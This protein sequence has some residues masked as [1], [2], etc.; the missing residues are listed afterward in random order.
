MKRKLEDIGMS[1]KESLLKE[2]QENNKK[3]EDKLNQAMKR[4]TSIL[5]SV[6]LGHMNGIRTD[7]N[8]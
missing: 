8:T 4:I 5:R 7:A 1:L 2:V 3:I 6:Q